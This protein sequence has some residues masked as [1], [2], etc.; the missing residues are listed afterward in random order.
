MTRFA[1]DGLKEFELFMREGRQAARSLDRVLEQIEKN[2]QS[3]LF[4]GS[5]IP[6]Y[7]PKQ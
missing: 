2:P 1:K 4:G 5:T 6:E 3:F 7:N